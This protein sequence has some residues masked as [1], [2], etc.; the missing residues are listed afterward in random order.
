MDVPSIVLAYVTGIFTAVVG[1]E[2]QR[3]RERST[4]AGERKNEVRGSLISELTRFVS[5]WQLFKNTSNMQVERG[6]ANY[7][8][9]LKQLGHAIRNILSVSGSLLQKDLVDDGMKISGDL[10]KMS[11][12]DFY[13]DGGIS[14]N[15]LI[16]FG[17][18]TARRCEALNKKLRT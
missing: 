15:E 5:G 17:D 3:Y 2:Y 14:F 11:L 4:R 18:E 16:K 13:A 8:A 10:I 1:Y 7:R 9:E 12:W 6:L